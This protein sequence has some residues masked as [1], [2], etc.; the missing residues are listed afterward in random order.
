[1]PYTEK[2]RTALPSEEKMA[3]LVWKWN[4]PPCW[5]FHNSEISLSSN[6][7]MG[8]ITWIPIAGNRGIW[9][10]MACQMLKNTWH[11]H[12]NAAL[13]LSENCFLTRSCTV[14]LPVQFLYTL[15]YVII[16]ETYIFSPGKTPH[17]LFFFFYAFIVIISKKELLRR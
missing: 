10:S 13:H 1:M 6:F 9:N 14:K 16:P 15:R 3:A 8:R 11:L 4:M 2:H 5:L 12:L 7:Y 17:H